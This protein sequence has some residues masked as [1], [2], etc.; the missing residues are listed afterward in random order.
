M[1]MPDSIGR[2]R[3]FGYLVEI[4]IVEGLHLGMKKA[5]LREIIERVFKESWEIIQRKSSRTGELSDPNRSFVRG[6][7]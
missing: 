6:G 5:E 4:A 2:R 1:L 7:S 3:I